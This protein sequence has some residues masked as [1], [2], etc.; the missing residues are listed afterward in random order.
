MFALTKAPWKAKATPTV[1]DIKFNKGIP[2]AINGKRYGPVLLVEKLNKLAGDNGVGRVDI[3]EN[4]LVGIKSRGVYETPAGTVLY[5]AH[6]D[7]ESLTLNREVLH[8]RQFVSSHY[9]EL[10][11]YGLWHSPLKKAL[12]GWINEVQSFVSGTVR[13]RLYKGNCTILGRSSPYS[14]YKKSLATFG[15]GDA[16]QH[17]DARGFIKLFGLPL[18]VEALR[19]REKLTIK[20]RLR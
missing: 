20:K 15:K 13:V 3:V 14:L 19:N 6:Q 9:A 8:Y 11:Y 10:I 17:H 4:R 18:K 7:L 2:V 16:W 5:L 12:D 1:L